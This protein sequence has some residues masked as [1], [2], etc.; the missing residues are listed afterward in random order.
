MDSDRFRVVVAL[1]SA[2]ILFGINYV[3]SKS[4]IVLVPPLIW[5]SSRNL[6][7]A[8]L[9]FGIAFLRRKNAPQLNAKFFATL[10][11][12]SLLG[13]VINQGTFLLGLSKTTA[14]NSAIIC[15]LIPVFTL[16][17]VAILGKES[18]T[19]KRII[20]F[21]VAFSGV[22]VLRKIEDFTVSDSTLIGDALILVNC[23]SYGLFLALSRPFIRSHD[24]VWISSWLF[25]SGGMGLGIL[26]APSWVHFQWPSVGP[27]L[28]AWMIFSV[29][30]C[31]LL[32]Y[33]L[34]VW[35]LARTNP[36]SVAIYVYL[37]PVVASLL[38]WTYLGEAM[39]IRT[40]ASSLFILI[41]MLLAL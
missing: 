35:A 1:V 13:I 40:L 2:Q 22:L 41:G 11:F 9:F 21:M 32:A 18:I 26:A 37:Q 20:G 5:A 12:Y 3:A 24:S 6:I 29:L 4:I 36:S 39:T 7:A 38:A 8:F 14:T 28:L 25:A 23:L 31:T 17:F 19:T 30:G 10:F 33:F 15:T 27:E 16:F 34:N